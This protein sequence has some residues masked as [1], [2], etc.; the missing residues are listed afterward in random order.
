MNLKDIG[1]EIDFVKSEKGIVTADDLIHTISPKTKI[2]SI[3][4]VQFLSGYKIDLEKL[5]TTCK[6]KGIIIS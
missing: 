4:F 2:I 1:V 6:E 3:S 5:G